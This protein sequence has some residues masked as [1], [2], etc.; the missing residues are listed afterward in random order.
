MLTETRVTDPN[1]GGSKGRKDCELAWIDAAALVEVGKVASYGAAKY[2]DPH[3]YRLG[4]AWSLSLNSLWRHVLAFQGGTDVDDESGLPHL[5]HAAWHCLTL[6][7]FMQE[8]REKDDRPKAYHYNEDGTLVTVEEKIERLAPLVETI[9][10]TYSDDPAETY[11]EDLAHVK[12]NIEG[13]ETDAIG[14]GVWWDEEVPLAERIDKVLDALGEQDAR[15]F[16]ASLKRSWDD[17]LER[18]RLEAEDAKIAERYDNQQMVIE[19]PEA[20][21]IRENPRHAVGG[22]RTIAPAPDIEGRDL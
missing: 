4:F 17:S 6:L 12:P 5:A 1:T 16:Q 2:E 22:F 3:N 21:Q 18:M 14:D 20:A 10:R 11:A 15:D 13:T 19:K 7:S 8:H 9:Q